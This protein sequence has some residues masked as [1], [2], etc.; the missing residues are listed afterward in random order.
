MHTR[1]VGNT[2]HNIFVY[3]RCRSLSAKQNQSK[4]GKSTIRKNISADFITK[5]TTHAGGK[6]DACSRGI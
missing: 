5:S 2:E 3:D 6:G 4:V 1:T